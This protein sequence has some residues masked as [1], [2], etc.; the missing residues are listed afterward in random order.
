M[1]EFMSLF[2]KECWAWSLQSCK[3]DVRTCFLMDGSTDHV[4][5]LNTTTQP[6]SNRR[7]E[8]ILWGQAPRV[9]ILEQKGAA[10]Q[11]AWDRSWRAQEQPS[12]RT[13]PT[14]PGP[15]SCR[16]KGP[17][18]QESILRTSGASEC[19]AS[20]FWESSVY[21]SSIPLP[22]PVPAPKESHMA[23]S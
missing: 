20:H 13:P 3:N 21:S 22:P 19:D 6:T 2:K 18:L 4:R 17:A 5:I 9:K 10:E 16:R 7:T 15:G 23:V 8:T 11:A 12:K 14:P 1:G